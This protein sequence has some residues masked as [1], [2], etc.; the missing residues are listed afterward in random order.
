MADSDKGVF[1]LAPSE[2]RAIIDL[3]RPLTETLRFRFE[4]DSG[5]KSAILRIVPL[6]DKTRYAFAGERVTYLRVNKDALGKV[7]RDAGNLEYT[8]G[9]SNFT[10]FMDDVKQTRGDISITKYSSRK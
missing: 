5:K 6:N 9:G 3:S 7:F 2:D 4:R 8:C 1:D 10:D